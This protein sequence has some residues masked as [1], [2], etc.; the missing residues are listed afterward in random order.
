[1]VDSDFNAKLIDFG[2][3]ANYSHL[4]DSFLRTYCG[5][6]SYTAPEML[7]RKKYLGEKVDVW[8]LGVSLYV[9]LEGMLPFEEKNK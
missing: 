8:C 6:P 1:M 2:L 3:A 7:E 4:E 5:S 9:M